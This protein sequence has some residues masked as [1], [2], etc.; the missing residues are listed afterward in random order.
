[1]L[2]KQ[3]VNIKD[4]VLFI[5]KFNI[6]NGRMYTKNNIPIAFM[7]KAPANKQRTS[8][9]HVD[10]RDM[11]FKFFFI[12]TLSHQ[13]IK[14]NIH[15]KNITNKRVYINPKFS[16]FPTKYIKPIIVVVRIILATILLII[17]NPIL[18]KIDRL[19]FILNLDLIIYTTRSMTPIPHRI[20]PITGVVAP[21]GY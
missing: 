18:I 19:Y 5:L 12:Y 4:F 7:V 15:S 9:V 3:Y 2:L 11:S 10:F 1:M 21:Q 13:R 16:V 17:V 8:I 20:Y 14:R 6:D